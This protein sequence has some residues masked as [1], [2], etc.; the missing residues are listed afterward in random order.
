MSLA[1]P[2]K[3]CYKRRVALAKLEGGRVFEVYREELDETQET[4]RGQLG[5]GPWNIG[6][7]DLQRSCRAT[8]E[9]FTAFDMNRLIF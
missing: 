9:C 5:W 6:I 3:W 1:L 7:G 8:D 2:S 4:G